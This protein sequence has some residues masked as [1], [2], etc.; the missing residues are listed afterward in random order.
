MNMDNK[1]KGKFLKNSSAKIEPICDSFMHMST[2]SEE[3][4]YGSFNSYS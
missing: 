1:S 2:V 3:V 4:K